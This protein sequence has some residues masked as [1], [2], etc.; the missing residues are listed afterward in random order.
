LE[1]N[2]DDPIVID[3]VVLCQKMNNINLIL[4]VILIEFKIINN[5]DLTNYLGRY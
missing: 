5:R 1:L 2:I 4:K 3:A